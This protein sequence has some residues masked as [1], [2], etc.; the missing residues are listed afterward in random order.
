M[1]DW[2]RYFEN[3]VAE[4]GFSWKG[5]W[6][7]LVLLSAVSVQTTYF[8]PGAWLMILGVLG[9]SY[10]QNICFALTARS[11]T[12]DNVAYHICAV[13]LSSFV[14]FLTFRT[15]LGPNSNFPLEYLLV[16][17]AGTMSGSLTGSYVS[18]WIESLTGARMEQVSKE[19]ADRNAER[20]RQVG[21]KFFPCLIG[22]GWIFQV[23]YFSNESFI[24][25]LFVTAFVFFPDMAYSM[26]T[27][28][29]NRDNYYLTLG[30]G[31]LTGVIDFFRWNFFVRLDMRW[32]VFVPYATGGTLGSVAGSL[33][34]S[35]FTK[36]FDKK[37]GNVS[38]ADAHVKK[39]EV[40]K[41]DFRPV[42]VLLG[43]VCFSVIVFPPKNLISAVW[44]V[45]ATVFMQFSFALIS[46]ARQRNN[47]A[48][49]LLAALCSNGSWFFVL[50]MV[51][52]MAKNDYSLFVPYAV[53][54]AIGSFVGAWLAMQIERKVGA[55]A[56]PNKI[57]SEFNIHLSLIPKRKP[58]S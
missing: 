47:D 10:G 39:G 22:F 32:G 29:Q 2:W 5:L 27:W 33:A 15:I 54:T 7:A 14:S 31:L 52:T 25:L 12:R 3:T 13:L 51:A 42:W 28:I 23:F 53:G 35:R 50:H 9:I 44:F 19:E 1:L 26:R 45:L 4:K 40:K 16:Y 43:M 8:T 34:A 21:L 38:S 17:I 36:W 57:A 58:R 11:R 37:T 49:H 55:F 41:P 20:N 56:D 6:P 30:V 48:Y 46:R 24:P 18:M